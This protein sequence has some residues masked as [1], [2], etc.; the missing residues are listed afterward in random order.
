MVVEESG[1]FGLSEANSIVTQV[2]DAIPSPQ[3]SITKNGQRANGFREIHAHERADTR[4]L[5]FENVV[6][7]ADGKVMASQGQSK[8]GKRSFLGAVDGVLPIPGLGSTDLLIASE[9][10][11]C[12][13]D[14]SN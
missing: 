14:G 8:V 7:G 12:G 9:K 6:I 5:Y 2:V 10:L 1:L 13:S 3:E 11:A 4:T